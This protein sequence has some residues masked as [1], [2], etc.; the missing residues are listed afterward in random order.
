M[1]AFSGFKACDAVYANSVT[2][3]GFAQ[4]VKNAYFSSGGNSQVTVHGDATG[5]D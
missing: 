5:Q 2:T 4:N 1:E 3:C